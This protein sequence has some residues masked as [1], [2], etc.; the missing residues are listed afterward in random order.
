MS[1]CPLFRRRPTLKT[2]NRRAARHRQ[3]KKQSLLSAKARARSRRRR[4]FRVRA[5]PNEFDA[6]RHEAARQWHRYGQTLES[7]YFASLAPAHPPAGIDHERNKKIY[8]AALTCDPAFLKPDERADCV[9]LCAYF[10]ADFDFSRIAPGET[11]RCA[12]EIF[13]DAARGQEGHANLCLDWGNQWN[14]DARPACCFLSPS[15]S[16]CSGSPWSFAMDTGYD[17]RRHARRKQKPVP[18]DWKFDGADAELQWKAGLSSRSLRSKLG[19]AWTEADWGLSIHAIRQAFIRNGAVDALCV[20]GF[21]ARSP[22]SLDNFETFCSFMQTA[23]NTLEERWEIQRD[24]PLGPGSPAP[25]SPR[26]SL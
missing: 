19:F 3:Y 13:A 4:R 16:F 18:A 26:K 1:H 24:T 9:L 22:S 6:M 21:F 23:T 14:L 2:H 17:R 10:P 12:V 7:R 25:A 15:Y 8:C 20:P 11:E 5:E